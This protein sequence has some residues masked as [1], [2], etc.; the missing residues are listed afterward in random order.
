[1]KH[2]LALALTLTFTVG[3]AFDPDAADEDV[4][5]ETSALLLTC[6]Q[7]VG[8]WC[9]EP[10]PGSTTPILRAVWAVDA[11]N[12]F[13]V[14]D[15]G[16]I[17]RRGASVWTAMSSGT[18]QNLN[19]VWAA[20]SSNVW[21]VGVA[22][23][24][25]R[26]NGTSWSAVTGVTT[27]NLGAVWGSSANDVWLAAQANVLHYNGTTFTT[28]GTFTGILNSISGTG[29]T[30]VWATGELSSVHHFNG[31]SWSTLNP[32]AGNT[33][34]TVLAIAAGDAWV[35][36]STSLKESVHFTGGTWVNK[37]TSGAVFWGL[38]AFAANDMW[39]AGANSKI[40]HWNGT[41]WT[42]STPLGSVNSLNSVTKATGNLWVV[43]DNGFIG[44]Q[45]L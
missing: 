15:A 20:S 36:D 28:S 21:A 27:S 26:F 11:S 45:A 14:G 42:T 9:Q 38:S 7:P 16:T 19:G 30:D 23:T 12:V 40:G 24:I 37:T 1:M 35:T 13:A 2:T 32:G 34:K 41:A 39:G 3:C 17:W 44:H 25:L 5:T 22:G 8:T 43:G 6:P 33:Y 10:G 31:S 18:T 4:S 29:T